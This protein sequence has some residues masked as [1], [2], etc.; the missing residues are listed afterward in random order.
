MSTSEES[1][2]GELTSYA[3]D[4][5]AGLGVHLFPPVIIDQKQKRSVI[6]LFN[7]LPSHQNNR[8]ILDMKINNNQINVHKDGFIFVKNENK[9]SV[10]KILNL[11]MA[12]GKFYD[13]SFDAVHE[14]E[15]A[16]TNY[17][18]QGSTITYMNCDDETKRTYLIDEHINQ[19]YH[20][21]P[22]KRIEI[23]LS[24]I[25]EI[26]SN[27]EKLLEHEKLSNNMRLFN[28]GLTDCNDLDFSSAFFKGWGVIERHYNDLWETLFPQEKSDQKDPCKQKKPYRTIGCILEELCKQNKINKKDCKILEDLRKKR[29]KVYHNG[30]QVTK[31]DAGNCLK[32]TM[33]ILRKR[34]KET[35]GISEDQMISE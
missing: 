5:Y 12:C 6:E 9:E 2:S 32:H 17:D 35:A 1:T 20:Y 3:N 7:N 26:L 30:E 31:E 28:E 34:I 13:F 16:M 27:T 15:L 8:K 29:N 23:K 10:L 25:Q 18:K 14:H 4:T 11:I 24:I 19:T 33:K 22:I 21:K